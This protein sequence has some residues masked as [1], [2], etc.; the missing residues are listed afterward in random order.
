[1]NSHFKIIK[2]TINNHGLK[3][4]L[5]LL[6]LKTI[7]KVV[8]LHV[9]SCII[10]SKVKPQSLEIDSRFEHGF[11]DEGQ[12]K[13]FVNDKENQLPPD[14]LNMALHKGDQCY[15]VIEKE[16]LASYGWYSNGE[17]MTDIEDLKFCFDPSYVYMYKGLTKNN[18]RG[19]RLHAVG[20]SWALHNFLEKG[21][22]GIVS[23]VESTNFD[24][25]KSCFR[26]GY[27]ETGKI[28]IMKLFGRIYQYTSTPC[29]KLNIQ[30]K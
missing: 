26:M 9:L 12:L 19:Q 24:S 3:N 4:A 28:Y 22:N 13:E 23:Y 29:R 11:L 16:N 10:I 5:Y 25:L 14:F 2:K 1:M 18:Y 7:N 6:S 27:E 30:L 8:K 17:T 15:A 20:M 21:F